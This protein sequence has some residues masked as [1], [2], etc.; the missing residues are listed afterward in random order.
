MVNV[1][2]GSSTTLVHVLGGA[3]NDTFNVTATPGSTIAVDGAGGTADNFTLN[4]TGG[5][6]T[7]TNANDGDIEALTLNSTGST[8]NVVT[9]SHAAN[10]IVGIAA[11]NKAT[12]TGTANLTLVGDPDTL[13]AQTIEK[14]SSY[15]GTFN[16]KTNAAASAGVTFQGISANQ[17]EISTAATAQ[18]VTINRV[19]LF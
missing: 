4:F 7:L 13:L 17:V 9:I 5:A 15:T 2:G 16:V 18:D 1:T 6:Y 11:G 12:V 3:A 19:R 14:G 8:A 10:D